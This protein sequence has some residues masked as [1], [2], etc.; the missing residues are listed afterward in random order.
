MNER[1]GRLTLSNNGKTG[2]A[3]QISDTFYEL[4]VSN[5]ILGKRIF[6]WGGGGY[7][8]MMPFILFRWGVESILKKEKNYV[9]YIHPWEV[10]LDQ[11]R[12]NE[13]SIICKFKHYVNLDKTQ[14][15]LSRL[16]EFFNHCRFPTCHQYLQHLKI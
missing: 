1:Y 12:V 13:A 16:L 6:P 10:D 11:P 14:S 4:P 8:R 7:F 2:I 9:F 3:Y 15:R 5:M